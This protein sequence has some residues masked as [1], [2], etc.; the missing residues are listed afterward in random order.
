MSIQANDERDQFFETLDMYRNEEKSVR[1]RQH[2]LLRCW[3]LDQLLPEVVCP[4]GKF[5]SA[6]RWPFRMVLYV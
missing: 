4:I 6:S 2:K 5:C 1:T 3:V